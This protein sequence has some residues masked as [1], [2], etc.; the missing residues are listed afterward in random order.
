M[1]TPNPADPMVNCWPL[2]GSTVRVPATSGAPASN[3]F[4]VLTLVWLT[5]NV[6]DPNTNPNASKVKSAATAV[7][8]PFRFRPA[9]PTPVWVQSS[10]DAPV[11]EARLSWK[12]P[13]VTEALNGAPTRVASR[14][15]PSMPSQL[16]PLAPG[17]ARLAVLMVP[18]V[19]WTPKPEPPRVSC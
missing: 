13:L 4:A 10:G 2:F 1:V 18:D 9:A 15:S 7:T 17:S 3:G 11:P 16:S 8:D 6:A 19:I 14:F 5:L 12:E